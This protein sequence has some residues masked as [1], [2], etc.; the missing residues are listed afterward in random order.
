VATWVAR[1]AADLLAM[2]RDD[3]RKSKERVVALRALVERDRPS[4]EAIVLEWLADVT[5][6]SNPKLGSLAYEAYQVGAL[7]ATEALVERMAELIY[8]KVNDVD[9]MLRTLARVDS[10][11]VAPAAIRQL[12]DANIQRDVARAH[13]I[14][15]TI[16]LARREVGDRARIAEISANAETLVGAERAEW[17]ARIRATTAELLALP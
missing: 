1:S 8:E 6:W 9:A 11:F 16:L 2:A 14:M 15:S 10:R 13:H 7:L 12:T 4:A 5:W 17:I 3:A